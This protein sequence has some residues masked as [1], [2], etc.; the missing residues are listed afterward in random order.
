M[1]GQAAPSAGALLLPACGC[2]FRFLH[3]LPRFLWSTTRH[4]P[5]GVQE[6]RPALACPIWL[7][8]LCLAV[9]APEDYFL[10]F[11]ELAGYNDR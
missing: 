11:E 6:S 2:Y 1:L 8:E 9:I 4:L 5:L 10:L 7:Q 3:H